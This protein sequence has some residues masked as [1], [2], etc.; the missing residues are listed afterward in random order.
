[1]RALFIA[2]LLVGGVACKREAAP[3]DKGSGLKPIRESGLR[4]P[5][6][7][8]PPDPASRPVVAS[9]PVAGQGEDAPPIPP[10]AGSPRIELG[11]SRDEFMARTVGCVERRLFI[12]AGAKRK[13]VEVFQT[14]PGDC[15]KKL[16]ERRFTLVELKLESI[17]AGLL[18]PE[19][20]TPAPPSNR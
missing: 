5:S 14:V 20:S 15:A 7:G 2:A 9:P 11:M 10:P 1:M 3:E 18:P 4:S 19:S 12:P 8:V 16:G 17:E 13:L 6:T